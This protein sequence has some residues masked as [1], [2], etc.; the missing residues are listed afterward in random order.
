MTLAWET[1]KILALSTGMGKTDGRKSLENVDVT[2]KSLQY[3]DVTG[4]DILINIKGQGSGTSVS[5]LTKH[6]EFQDL[7][8]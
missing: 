3:V 4:K 6:L 8:K 2:G 1:E 7:R 5:V